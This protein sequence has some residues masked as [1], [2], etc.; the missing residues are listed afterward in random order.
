VALF[1]E[2]LGVPKDDLP[3]GTLIAEGADPHT[4]RRFKDKLPIAVVGHPPV[5]HFVHVTVD[6][7]V[8]TF[9]RFLQTHGRLFSALPTW[10]VWRTA[11]P[12]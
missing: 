6:G 5:V 3:R 9:E 7:S 10:A 12:R 8:A 1:T 4:T 11:L 2:Q